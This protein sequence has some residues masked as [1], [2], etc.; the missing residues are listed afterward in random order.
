[1]SAANTKQLQE[2]NALMK[3]AKGYLS[4]TLTRWSPD[5]DSAAVKFDKAAVIFKNLKMNKETYD[6]L[7]EA[8]NAHYKAGKYVYYWRIYLIYLYVLFFHF[9][10]I[11]LFFAG[12]ACENAANIMRDEKKYGEAM[13]DYEKA[14]TVFL[15]DGKA[16]KAA[17]TLK[18]AARYVFI[19]PNG[20]IMCFFIF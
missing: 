16:T 9:I 7:K 3:E 17:E 20:L 6:A 14:A 19:G 5:Y 11:S 8:A 12:K 10:Y 15:E 2:G 1:M 13:A 4:R 18:N